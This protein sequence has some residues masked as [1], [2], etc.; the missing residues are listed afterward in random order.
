MNDHPSVI[1]LADTSSS[2]LHWSPE[3]ALQIHSKIIVLM[4]DQ[5]PHLPADSTPSFSWVASKL[6]MIGLIE[7]HE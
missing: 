1:K 6:E 4:T 7:V 2:N 5:S 3:E